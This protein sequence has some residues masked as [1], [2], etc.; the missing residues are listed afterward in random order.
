MHPVW[1]F[2]LFFLENVSSV[3]AN[4]LQVGLSWFV[5]NSTGFQIMKRWLLPFKQLDSQ[6]KATATSGCQH[7]IILL[8][9]AAARHMERSYWPWTHWQHGP[10]SL[11]SSQKDDW[12]ICIYKRIYVEDCIWD[13]AYR[14]MTW[15]L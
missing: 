10:L 7:I 1:L 11:S 14:R 4:N 13:I 2:F 12:N 6:C 8:M 5:E 9:L 3:T 15:I